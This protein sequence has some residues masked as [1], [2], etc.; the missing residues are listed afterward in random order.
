MDP[1]IADEQVFFIF[2]LESATSSGL[3]MAKGKD[4]MPNIKSALGAK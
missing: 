2:I 4:L 1:K 3:V